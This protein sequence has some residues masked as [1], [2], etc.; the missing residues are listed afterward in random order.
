MAFNIDTSD[1][2]D[3]RLLGPPSETD[4]V[5]SNTEAS[6]PEEVLFSTV[7]FGASFLAGPGLRFVLS[8]GVASLDGTAA[9]WVR[10]TCRSGSDRILVLLR[11]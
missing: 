9:E 7:R 3:W 10:R 11:G 5:S 8:W 4:L 6:S 1:V 2:S